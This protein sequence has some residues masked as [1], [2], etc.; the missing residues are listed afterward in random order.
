MTNALC[1]RP[2]CSEEILALFERGVEPEAKVSA[3]VGEV[4]AIFRIC[5]LSI[6]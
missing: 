2:S 6:D 4:E 5:D 1:R 3:L